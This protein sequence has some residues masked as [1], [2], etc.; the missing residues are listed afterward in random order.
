MGTNYYARTEACE[1]CGRSDS[2]VHICKSLTMFRGYTADQPC[3]LGVIESVA[4]WRRVLRETPKLRVFDE[5][6]REEEIA[7]FLDAID[8]TQLEQRRRQYD[9]M[10]AHYPGQTTDWLDAE[11]FSFCSQEFC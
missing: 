6:G 11:G 3:A 4:D 10:Q 7:A 1:H 9:W 8:A 2:D 5:Y